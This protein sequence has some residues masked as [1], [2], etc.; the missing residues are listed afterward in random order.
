L[1]CRKQYL[2]PFTSALASI[3][4][5][6][7][8]TCL[9]NVSVTSLI[10]FAANAFVTFDEGVTAILNM[11]VTSVLSLVPLGELDEKGVDSGDWDWIDR[12]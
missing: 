6:F 10:D 4:P 5:P 11:L 1:E 7:S 2:T 12:N 8:S 9:T 3:L